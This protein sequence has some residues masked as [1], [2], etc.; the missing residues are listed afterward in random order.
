MKMASSDA[1]VLLSSWAADFKMGT[2]PDNEV[3]DVI[4]AIVDAMD[5]HDKHAAK[6]RALVYWNIDGDAQ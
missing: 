6:Q 1:L 3:V 5:V 2:V 4:N